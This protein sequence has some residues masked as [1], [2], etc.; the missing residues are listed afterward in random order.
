M[1]VPGANRGRLLPLRGQRGVPLSQYALQVGYIVS[2]AWT[3]M[4]AVSCA[5]RCCS[6]VTFAWPGFNNAM[7][8]NVGMTVRNILSKKLMGGYQVER[9]LRGCIAHTIIIAACNLLLLALS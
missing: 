4:Q 7:A 2:L 1:A 6:Q 3:G 5:S 9:L 8:S